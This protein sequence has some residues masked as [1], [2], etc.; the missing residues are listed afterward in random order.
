MIPEQ[1][2]DFCVGFV[3]ETQDRVDTTSRIRTSIDVIAQEYDGVTGLRFTA[4][5]LENVAEGQKIAVDV[6][7]SDRRQSA[8]C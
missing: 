1:A 3:A 4:E 8:K 5:L 7:D 2:N 6:A